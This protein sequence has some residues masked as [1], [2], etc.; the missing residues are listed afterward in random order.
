M[1]QRYRERQEELWIQVGDGSSQP[2]ESSAPSPSP[3]LL[4][5]T[6][7]DI[8]RARLELPKNKK[9]RKARTNKR[10]FDSSDRQTKKSHHAAADG[11]N[12]KPKSENPHSPKSPAPSPSS[13]PASSPTT[14][15]ATS[16]P[17]AAPTA[18]P[19]PPSAKVP[20]K[21][22]PPPKKERNGDE[23]KPPPAE[24]V[25]VAATD[26]ALISQQVSQCVGLRKLLRG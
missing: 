5:L 17:T 12:K 4:T 24:S 11:K 7:I 20:P 16:T 14:T 18:P 26:G 21:P 22:K 10:T 13:S 9:P 2:A 15:A 3:P 23:A 8:L 25:P 19:Y 1:A 6:P